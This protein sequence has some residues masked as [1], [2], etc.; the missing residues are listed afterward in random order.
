MKT[1]D[2]P[3]IRRKQQNILAFKQG[4]NAS[5]AVSENN[6]PFGTDPSHASHTADNTLIL[7]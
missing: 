6:V 3:F 7:M 1:P 4:M 5:I 2:Y